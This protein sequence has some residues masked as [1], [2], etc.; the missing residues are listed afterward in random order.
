MIA[1]FLTMPINSTSAIIEITDSSVLVTNSAS[2]APTPAAGSVD[3]IVTGC[4][5]LSYSMPS[6]RYTVMMAASTRISIEFGLSCT[7]KPPPSLMRMSP[8]R[9]RPST[10]DLMIASPSPVLTPGARL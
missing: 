1:F 3:R 7:L 4:T 9:R 2:S 6:T 10:V 5:R 8:G